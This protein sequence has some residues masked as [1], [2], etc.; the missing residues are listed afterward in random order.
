M[1]TKLETEIG[2]TL[3]RYSLAYDR[4]HSSANMSLLQQILETMFIDPEL[5]AELSKDQVRN[6]TPV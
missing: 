3:K 2:C 1:G 6:R 4:R 5:L